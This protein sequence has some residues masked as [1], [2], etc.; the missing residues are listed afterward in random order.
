VFVASYGNGANPCTFGSPCKTFQQAVNVVASGGEVTAI[1]S[2]GFGSITIG[3]AVTITSPPGVEAGIAAAAGADGIDIVAPGA[4]VVL[5][6]LTLLGANAANQGIFVST[7]G[8][9]EIIGCVVKDFKINGIAVQT[10]G[11]NTE[12]SVQISNT[13]VTDNSP[14]S[15]DG[16]FFISQAGGGKIIASLDHV[17]VSNSGIGIQPEAVSAPIEIMVTDSHR[18]QN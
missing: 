6:G 1:D 8:R 16:I 15:D 9:V 5:R 17:T 7:A 11:S 14:G 13:I 18:A 10:S 2:A 4:T 12:M 3:Q